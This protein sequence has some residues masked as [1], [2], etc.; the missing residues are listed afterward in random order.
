M[1][2]SLAMYYTEFEITYLSL[3][4]SRVITSHSYYSALIDEAWPHVNFENLA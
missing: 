1:A 3:E 2:F 4:V